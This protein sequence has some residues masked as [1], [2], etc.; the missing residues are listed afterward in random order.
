[1]SAFIS[2]SLSA[3]GGGDAA[4]RL[5]GGNWKQNDRI[6]TGGSGY[7]VTLGSC[8]DLLSAP[9]TDQNPIQRRENY[10]SYP[11]R[12]WSKAPFGGTAVIRS[13]ISVSTK[14]HAHEALFL[15]VSTSVFFHL[16][17]T[18]LYTNY[19]RRLAVVSSQHGS[20]GQPS[21]KLC[22]LFASTPTQLDPA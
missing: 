8:I 13:L 5:T 15:V 2:S 9:I 12:P 10:R 7:D 4:H 11:Q 16:I 20:F 1:V 3:F 21:H 6:I 14:K 18:T 22:S 17:S 19:F